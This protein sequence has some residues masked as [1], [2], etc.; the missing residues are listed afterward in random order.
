[1]VGL[2]AA[3]A[4]LAAMGAAGVAA[5]RRWCCWLTP[6]ERLAYGVP[7]GVAGS[8]LALLPL[9][10]L[11]G[12]SGL[13][14]VTLGVV[15]AVVALFLWPGRPSPTAARRAL[16]HLPGAGQPGPWLRVRLLPLLVL[17]AFTLRWALLWQGALT[18][19]AD[20]L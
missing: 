13:L 3:M 17:S 5:L 14:V 20:V 12:F 15:C 8:S 11:M 4:L 7:L 9:A 6:L 10:T 16:A 18:Y 1:M 19:A 2:V